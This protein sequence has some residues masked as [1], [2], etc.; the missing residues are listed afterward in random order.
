MVEL[1]ESPPLLD[2]YLIA[3]VE[4]HC[5]AHCHEA[6]NLVGAYTLSFAA[7]DRAQ[8]NMDYQKLASSRELIE[9]AET[10]LRRFLFKTRR[11]FAARLA[12]R[13]DYAI[14]PAPAMLA[15]FSKQ[16]ARRGRRVT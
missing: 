16:S 2:S 9:Q 15:I 11:A 3:Q 13:D 10:N 12:A 7:Y 4:Q 1:S 5:A 6:A 8:R 14:E